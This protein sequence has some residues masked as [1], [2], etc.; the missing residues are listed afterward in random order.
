MAFSGFYQNSI[1]LSK[2]LYFNVPSPFFSHSHFLFVSLRQNIKSQNK[3]VAMEIKLDRKKNHIAASDYKEQITVI[4]TTSD[5][6]IGNNVDTNKI[7]GN[8]MVKREKET[9]IKIIE[10]RKSQ[11]DIIL[12]LNVSLYSRYRLKSSQLKYYRN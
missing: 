3:S 10:L 1:V 4:K 8:Y 12:T 2:T 5:F 7:E 6:K 9:L 11:R